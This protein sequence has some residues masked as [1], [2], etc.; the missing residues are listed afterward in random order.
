MLPRRVASRRRV[1]LTLVALAMV[2]GVVACG[3]SEEPAPAEAQ[4][5]VV[6]SPFQPQHQDSI[7]PPSAQPPS[8]AD[9]SVPEV[10]FDV[11][12]LLPIDLIAGA[13][14]ETEPPKTE[15]PLIRGRSAEETRALRDGQ[16]GL[17][18]CDVSFGASS[19]IWDWPNGEQ[20]REAVK[21]FLHTAADTPTAV[22]KSLPADLVPYGAIVVDPEYQSASAQWQRDDLHVVVVLGYA[23]TGMQVADV[24]RLL[25]RIVRTM[26]AKL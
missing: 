6:V 12:D 18:A 3:D 9:S 24:Q 15:E 7:A 16:D 4:P 10:R 26:D 20:A 19:Q 25:L 8:L 23:E 17:Y 2:G 5:S 13:G 11:C 21:S 14:I 22:R 1:F